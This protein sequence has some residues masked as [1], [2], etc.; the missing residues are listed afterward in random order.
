MISI[1][2]RELWSKTTDVRTPGSDNDDEMCLAAETETP[3]DKGMPTSPG[4][5][6]R[7]RETGDSFTVS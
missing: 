6:H 5:F 3:A 2:M 4:E 1:E 7:Q